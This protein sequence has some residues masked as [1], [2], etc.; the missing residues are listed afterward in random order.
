MQ[1]V[2]R[3]EPNKVPGTCLASPSMQVDSDDE[4][5]TEL[6]QSEFQPPTAPEPNTVEEPVKSKPLP[7][8]TMSIQERDDISDLSMAI[9]KK[10]KKSK[11]KK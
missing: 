1:K 11:R 7:M 4:E 8:D 5:T 9:K 2:S 6:L 10:K 3:P